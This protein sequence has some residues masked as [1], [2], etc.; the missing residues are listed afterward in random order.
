M[1]PEL[2]TRISILPTLQDQ[3]KSEA[4]AVTIVARTPETASRPSILEFII[5]HCLQEASGH[6]DCQRQVEEFRKSL[7]EVDRAINE[8]SVQRFGLSAPEMKN[9]FSCLCGPFSQI[10]IMNLY[11]C[12]RELN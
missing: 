1:G 6:Q 3:T 2:V 12:L 9:A 11:S 4:W 8:P 7:L 5:D 10:D